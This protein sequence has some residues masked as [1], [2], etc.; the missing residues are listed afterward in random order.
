MLVEEDNALVCGHCKKVVCDHPNGF[1]DDGFCRICGTSCSHPDEEGGYAIIPMIYDSRCPSCGGQ[2]K[3]GDCNEYLRLYRHTG[4]YSF[5]KCLSCGC[6]L[7][8]NGVD[9]VLRVSALEDE[10]EESE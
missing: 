3:C 2:Y 1:D 10:D 4:K 7:R 5:F 8:I 9:Y 6:R